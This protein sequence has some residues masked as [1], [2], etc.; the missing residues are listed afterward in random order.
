MHVWASLAIHETR[1]SKVVVSMNGSW[2][3]DLSRYERTMSL[4]ALAKFI[5][6]KS[7]DDD[8]DDDDNDD[9]SSSNQLGLGEQLGRV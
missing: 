7:D 9:K 6:L 4:F 1:S 2:P 8:D 5:C 3:G